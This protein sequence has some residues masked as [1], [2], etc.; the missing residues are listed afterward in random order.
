VRATPF[1]ERW[2]R[3]DEPDALRDRADRAAALLP[4][5]RQA[6]LRSTEDRS[7]SEQG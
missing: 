4:D 5:L 1:Y 3:S 2:A 6:A 7:D